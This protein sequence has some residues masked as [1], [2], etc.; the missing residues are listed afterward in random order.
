MSQPGYR[1]RLYL[2]TALLLSGFGVLVTR[3]YEFQIQRQDEFTG[4][5]PT[6]STVSVREPGVRGEIF[7]R[8]GVQLAR[9][10][11]HYEL[12][13]NLDEVRQAHDAA[14]SAAFRADPLPEKPDPDNPAAAEEPA[15]EPDIVE[16][17]RQQVI[18]PLEAMPAHKGLLRDFSATAMR[19]HYKTHGGLV[20]FSYRSD[21]SYDEFAKCG[22]LNLTIPGVYLTI[23]PQRS[24]PYGS[25]ASHV[26][27]Y[28]QPWEPADIPEAAKRRFNHYIGDPKGADGVES[29]MNQVLRGQEGVTTLLKNENGH[30]IRM[31]DRVPPAG[32]AR[33]TLTL[34]A[35]SQLYVENVLREHT[36]RAAAVV[37]E[38]ETGEIIAM[39]SVPDYNPNDFV[40]SISPERLAEYVA[41]K[42][43]DP[44]SNRAIRSYVPGSTFKVPTAIAGIME[45]YAGRSFTCTGAV[46]YGSKPIRCWIGQRGGSHGT[47]NLTR[48]IQQSCN[49][50]FMILANTV[51]PRKMAEDLTLLNLG[52]RTGVE[53][54]AESPGI[55]P[56]NQAWRLSGNNR[57]MTPALTAM[58]AIGQGDA[59]ATPLQ[60]CA[61]TA[62][63]ANKGKYHQPRIVK[64]AVAPD[65]RVLIP[66]KPV[67]SLDLS[68]RPGV[69]KG[70]ELLRKGMWMAVNQPGGTAGRA[71]IE[72]IE[73]AAKTGTAQAQVDGKASHNSWLIAFAPFDKPKYAVAVLV[74]HAGSGGKV[75]GP[76]A[77]LI[78]RG[79][80]IQD[81]GVKLPLAVQKPVLG[82]TRKIDE[83]IFPK[84]DTLAAVV[85]VE[86]DDAGDTGDELDSSFGTLPPGDPEPVIPKPAVTPTVDED[87]T[88]VPNPIPVEEN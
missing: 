10:I 53:L 71:R 55:L 35:R 87:G 73:V 8:N 69:P 45:G 5:M 23:R 81:E 85:T 43:M 4:M 50:Y 61:V 52:R 56:G 46:T 14:Q 54:P 78:L 2:L 33:L 51:G 64:S 9:N 16:M 18:T 75:C 13:F 80:F 3:L 65:G 62:C 86:D 67:L 28:I 49:P 15:A 26:L 58:L 31:I 82:H 70:M 38:V 44:F 39:A 42:K 7:D 66:D 84:D 60:L 48:A 34:D 6:T 37:M 11:I 83:V 57:V 47:L 79:L 30:I 59:M 22:E 41:N 20:P 77:Q 36:G 21:L 24:Y 63:V 25:L 72:D 76:I 19:V 40:P 88:L 17:F 68:T 29:S 74:Q 32:G 12:A 27:G 1:M